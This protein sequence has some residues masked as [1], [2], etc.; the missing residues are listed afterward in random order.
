MKLFNLNSE[1]NWMA[2]VAYNDLGF[3]A[4]QKELLRSKK[5]EDAT[6]KAELVTYWKTIK[7]VAATAEEVTLLSTFLDSKKPTLKPEE[8]LTIVDAIIFVKEGVPTNG[9]FSYKINEGK[10]K[11]S[12]L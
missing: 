11:H 7:E 4:E 8:T 5:E 9:Q 1:G 2:Q 12:K 3:T 10:I 6:A